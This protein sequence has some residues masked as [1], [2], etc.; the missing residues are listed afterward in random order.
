M[1]DALGLFARTRE[2]VNAIEIV[3]RD[4]YT[5][6]VLL[7]YSPAQHSSNILWE[8]MEVCTS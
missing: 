7:E 1:V 3:L 4:V 2:I 8:P 6:S 5:C